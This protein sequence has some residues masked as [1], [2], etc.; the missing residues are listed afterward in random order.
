MRFAGPMTVNLEGVRLP[1]NLLIN[2][3]PLGVEGRCVS[4][5]IPVNPSGLISDIVT[6]IS[7]DSSSGERPVSSI[8]ILSLRTPSKIILIFS[9][10]VNS[11]IF[12]L[13]I[14]S[15]CIPVFCF[16]FCIFI[17]RNNLLFYHTPHPYFPLLMQIVV[18]FYVG[19]RIV[20]LKLDLT[21]SD[22]SY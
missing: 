14:R 4:I 22:R 3:D 12:W 11:S 21:S 13:L 16:N 18:R 9:M 2:A 5:S 10:V 1:I 15:I 8:T 7:L 19:G 6:S 17:T 20:Q